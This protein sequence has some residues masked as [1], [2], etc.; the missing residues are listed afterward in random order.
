MKIKYLLILLIA[1]AFTISSCSYLPKPEFKRVGD[2]SLTPLDSLGYKIIA[3]A[4]Y[5]NPTPLTITFKKVNLD[6]YLNNK[7]VGTVNQNVSTEL[8]PKQETI[9]P[10]ELNLR[11]EVIMTQVLN[12]VLDIFSTKKKRS[13]F[14]F[15]GTSTTQILGFSSENPVEFKTDID[16]NLLNLVK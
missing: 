2:V 7:Q 5:Y 4:I 14:V 6:V 9:V 15:K 10:V 8:F 13:T 16:L 3:N 12:S 1:F 11:Q